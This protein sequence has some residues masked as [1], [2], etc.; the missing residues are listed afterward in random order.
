MPQVTGSLQK[1]LQ[2]I[3]FLFKEN[4]YSLS[5]WEK[6]GLSFSITQPPPPPL[7]KTN[8]VWVWF[9]FFFE[10]K[11]DSTHS[12]YFSKLALL[13]KLWATVS[14]LVG[15]PRSTPMQPEPVINCTPGCF[16]NGTGPTC[17]GSRGCGT[18]HHGSRSCQMKIGF[19]YSE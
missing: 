8:L 3:H 5:W 1:V 12:C 15:C 17:Q 16:F 2:Q 6:K 19:R 9:F 7:K 11:Y 10:K 4:L 14:L 18:R 13:C